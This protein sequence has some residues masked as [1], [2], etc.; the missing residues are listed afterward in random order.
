VFVSFCHLDANRV[1]IVITICS[2]FLNLPVGVFIA[3]KTFIFSKGDKMPVS[4]DREL[5]ATLLKEIYELY[6]RKQKLEDHIRKLD[7]V[8]NSL[9]EMAALR[10]IE[11][12]KSQLFLS[13]KL[14]SR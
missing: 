6:A 9:Q 5:Q 14:S 10:D 1:S 7:A 13:A 8:N 12:R 11:A 4:T 2:N 3:S